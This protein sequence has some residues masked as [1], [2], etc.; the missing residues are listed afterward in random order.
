MSQH[1]TTK[2]CIAVW[3]KAY[4]DREASRRND[5]YTL[6]F[7]DVANEYQALAIENLLRAHEVD[8]EEISFDVSAVYSPQDRSLTIFCRSNTAKVDVLAA[9]KEQREQVCVLR[10]RAI[11]RLR[12]HVDHYDKAIQR[13][14][15]PGGV[16][17]KCTCLRR[18]SK[19]K[20]QVPESLTWFP[21]ELYKG[22]V[23]NTIKCADAKK[24][25]AMDATLEHSRC[26]QCKT[27]KESSKPLLRLA[28]NA[29]HR[30]CVACL[31]NRAS[32]DLKSI[33]WI[34]KDC[35]PLM[36]VGT[37]LGEKLFERIVQVVI[38]IYGGTKKAHVAYCSFELVVDSKGKGKQPEADWKIVITF[39]SGKVLTIVVE[40]DGASHD[41]AHEDALD[42]VLLM[43]KFI[44]TDKDYLLFL[45]V[46]TDLKMQL[47]ARMWIMHVC[48]IMY[49]EVDIKLSQFIYI[50][51]GPESCTPPCKWF[52]CGTSIFTDQPPQPL[53]MT[54]EE[55]KRVHAAVRDLAP[56]AQAGG[57]VSEE[58]QQEHLSQKDAQVYWQDSPTVGCAQSVLNQ[59]KN[60]S[61]KLTT[62]MQLPAECIAPKFPVGDLLENRPGITI[63]LINSV[64]KCMEE[65]KTNPS[66]Q[67]YI[68]HVQDYIIADPSCLPVFMKFVS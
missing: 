3:V 43:D 68:K 22:R 56:I 59:A 52:E 64:I 19:T 8:T 67:K 27:T 13:F 28:S 4:Q 46:A 61:K 40:I 14:D 66:G 10:Q 38:D 33:A 60:P 30:Q 9:P 65:R 50:V 53:N 15:D 12:E 51:V 20:K 31:Y 2:D 35:A 6:T 42:P 48:H 49:E 17:I 1:L 62:G 29:D 57:I 63:T 32:K 24:I 34:C 54:K 5:D 41:N 25:L 47:I 26:D 44:K 16:A 23:R 58:L 11:K 36:G 7:P 18:D 55:A 45:R 21:A 37:N 39:P